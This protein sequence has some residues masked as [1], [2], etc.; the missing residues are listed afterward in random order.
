MKK[1]TTTFPDI[2]CVF[3]VQRAPRYVA[4]ATRS[5]VTIATVISGPNPS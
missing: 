1:S 2:R 5:P 3:P 4:I